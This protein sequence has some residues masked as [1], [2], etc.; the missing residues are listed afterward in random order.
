MTKHITIKFPTDFLKIKIST[1]GSSTGSYFSITGETKDCG[2]C[3]HDEILKE[4]PDLAPLVALH[5]S[6]LDG[7][8]M[9][10]EA[11]GFYWLAK[12]AGI[13]MRWEPE[14]DEATCLQFYA[15]H[16]RIDIHD[17]EFDAAEVKKLYDMGA[18]SVATSEEVTEKC[19][20]DMH[21]AGVSR[22]QKLWKKF[23]DNMRPRW[24]A[25]AIKGLALIES[26]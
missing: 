1:D 21:K 11:N 18:R 19:K 9:H 25:E 8:P 2:G 26:L 4:R 6:D 24:K 16:C 17:A 7:V 10:A 12:A 15:N 3:I 14:Q 13:P 5:L 20:E 23:C 22:A